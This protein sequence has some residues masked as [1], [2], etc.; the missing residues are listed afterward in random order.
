[1]PN[2]GSVRAV[3]DTNVLLSGLLWR[4]TPH[5]LIER[6]H[7]GTVTL[8]TSPALLAELT[9]VIARRKFAAILTR[10][11]TDPVRTLA[12][13]RQAAEMIDPPQLP[14][15]VIRADP[16]DDAVLALAIAARAK[17]I[18]SGDRH[19]LELGSH[20]G[21]QILTPADALQLIVSA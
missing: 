2:G 20:Q 16:D 7:A 10:T 17:M 13:L 5:A 4:G 9:E 12:K 6:V 3:I 14:A 15:P 21:I 1:M 19:L 11:H 18:V 8:I